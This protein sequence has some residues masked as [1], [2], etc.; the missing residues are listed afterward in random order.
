MCVCVC[1]LER[2]QEPNVCM[3]KEKA[4]R[5]TDKLVRGRLNHQSELSLAIESV[6]VLRVQLLVVVCCL[7]VQQSVATC[8]L[9]R[10]NLSSCHSSQQSVNIAQSL[11]TVVQFL[12][13]YNIKKKNKKTN[14]IF[15]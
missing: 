5:I 1:V 6:L 7:S 12:M 10:A 14:T 3:F 8:D 9:C 11:R 4:L 2:E 15:K 13:R